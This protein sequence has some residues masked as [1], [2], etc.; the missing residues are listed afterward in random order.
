MIRP[1]NR[2]PATGQP[3]EGE[4]GTVEKASGVARWTRW[5]A[6]PV[7]CLAHT[8]EEKGGEHQP[9]K[10]RA[11]KMGLCGTLLL[12]AANVLEIKKQQEYGLAGRVQVKKEKQQHGVFI[13][14]SLVE[15]LTEMATSI[16]KISK[17]GTFLFAVGAFFMHRG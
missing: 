10:S 8:L 13:Q 4:R 6:R 17:T 15:N 16:P 14:S 1:L 12:E 7:I 3:G 9:R 2:P 5:E 11:E